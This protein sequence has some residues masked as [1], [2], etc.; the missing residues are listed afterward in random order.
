MSLHCASPCERACLIVWLLHH[1]IA[2]RDMTPTQQRPPL[3][4]S[5]LNRAT[6][7]LSTVQG[8]AFC[9]YADTALTNYVIQA[10]NGKPVGN[11]FLTVKRALAPAPTS[12]FDLQ[13]G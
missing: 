1:L 12:P 3:L 13:L 2:A 8:Y 10:L 9:E 7:S 11:K 4:V 5:R 6:I